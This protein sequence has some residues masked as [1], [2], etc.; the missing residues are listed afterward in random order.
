M[1]RPLN[2]LFFLRKKNLSFAFFPEKEKQIYILFFVVFRVRQRRAEPEKAAGLRT[3]HAGGRRDRPQ[4]VL[5]LIRER[6]ADGAEA[7]M[8]IKFV[9]PCPTLKA[10]ERPLKCCWRPFWRSRQKLFRSQTI[11]SRQNEESARDAVAEF[12]R[13]FNRRRGVA[14]DELSVENFEINLKNCVVSLSPSDVRDGAKTQR[15]SELRWW[16]GGVAIRCQSYKV[17]F[18]PSQM[19]VRWTSKSNLSSTKSVTKIHIFNQWIR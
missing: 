9:R 5:L 16:T 3:M 11:F 18:S 7:T 1:I 4:H 15:R 8:L 10:T 19:W 17:F 14:S 12:Q 6:K 2:F 13:R